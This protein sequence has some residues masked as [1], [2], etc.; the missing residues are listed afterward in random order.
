MKVFYDYVKS[1]TYKPCMRRKDN[2]LQSV[3]QD[4][5]RGKR[6]FNLNK[7]TVL[8]YVLY[9]QI[10][11]RLRVFCLICSLFYARENKLVISQYYTLFFKIKTY[12][13]SHIK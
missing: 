5:S 12:L 11:T 4:V 3:F 8:I 7:V 10:N 9:L 13:F 1:A 6:R 2:A